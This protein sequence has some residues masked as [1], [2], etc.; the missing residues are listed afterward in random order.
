MMELPDYSFYEFKEAEPNP[1]QGEGE[2][3]DAPKRPNPRSTLRLQV[4]LAGVMILG[5]LAES[6]SRRPSA[7]F[8]KFRLAFR[9]SIQLHNRGGRGFW[10][11]TVTPCALKLSQTSGLRHCW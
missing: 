3:G 2:T 5:F 9:C 4:R 8:Q 7:E 10:G 6:F 11:I 1:Y